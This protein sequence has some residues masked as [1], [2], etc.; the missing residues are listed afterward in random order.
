[1]YLVL[2]LLMVPQ[3]DF[4]RQ[5]PNNRAIPHHDLRKEIKIDSTQQLASKIF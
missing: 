2:V 1:M 5:E 3:R 4:G